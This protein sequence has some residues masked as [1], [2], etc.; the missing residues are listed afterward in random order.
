M[1][2][3]VVEDDPDLGDAIVRR[4]RREG[5]AVDWQRD[6]ESADDVLQYQTYELVV[7][8]I[9]LPKMD[10]FAVL[11]DLRKRGN[12][13]PV[14]MLTA[15]S[16][17]EDRVDALDVGADD[18]L[19]KPFDL[20]EFDARC[21]ALMRRSQGLASGVSTIGELIFDRGAKT[22]TIGDAQLNLPKRE[23]RLLEIFVGNLGRMLS[24]D[25]IA[26]QLFDFDDEAGPNA[27]ELYVGRLRRKLGD[28]LTIRTV[29]GLGYVAE[30]KSSRDH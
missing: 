20:R 15:R 9:G 29:R 14:L 21:R 12:K 17:I 6:G 8:D 23:Y 16:D 10:G 24:K 18:Y 11:R 26:S 2:I 19:S 22:A 3:L 5:H 25:Q 27:I 28:A 1:R 30:A 13:T 7:L 4:M